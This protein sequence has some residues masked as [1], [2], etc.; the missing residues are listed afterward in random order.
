MRLGDY[1]YLFA[2]S[3]MR[4]LRDGDLGLRILAVVLAVGLWIFR[5]RRRAGLGRAADGAGQL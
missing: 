3:G 1:K 2:I 5:Q 4:R